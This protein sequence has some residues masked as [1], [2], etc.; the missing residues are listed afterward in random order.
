MVP[1]SGPVLGSWEL[2]LIIVGVGF[3]SSVVPYGLEQVVLRRA[4]AA[5]FAVLMA[6]LPATAAVIGAVVLRQWPHGLEL[7]GLVL[8]SGAIALTSAR[9][10]PRPVA[11]AGGVPAVA[12]TDDGVPPA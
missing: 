4:T 11:D 2:A 9:R 6:T 12:A 10:R 1:R 5:T 7:V 8:V 3:M